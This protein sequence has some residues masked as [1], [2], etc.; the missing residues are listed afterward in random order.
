[1]NIMTTLQKLE[2]DS[3]PEIKAEAPE[4]FINLVESLR[5]INVRAMQDLFTRVTSPTGKKFLLDAMP[6]VASA[7][8]LVLMR[9]LLLD[10]RLTEKQIDAWLTSLI[11]IKNPTIEM[12]A[13][14]KVLRDRITDRTDI[15]VA[16]FD[17]TKFNDVNCSHLLTTSLE[18]KLS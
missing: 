3:V 1:M 2:A 12:L 11:F 15:K 10:G 4:Q 5:L 6:L 8:S 7:P 9:D 13:A 14:L 16:A 17:G 18:A